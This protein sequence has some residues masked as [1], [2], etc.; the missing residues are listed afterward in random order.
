MRHRRWTC[1]K[2]GQELGVV[3]PSGNGGRYLDVIKLRGVSTAPGWFILTCHC[4]E[5]TR[6]VGDAVNIRSAENAARTSVL[7]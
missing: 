7:T 5:E 3:R 6:W 1:Q 4:G 2:C